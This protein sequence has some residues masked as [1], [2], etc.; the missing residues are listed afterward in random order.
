MASRAALDLIVELKGNADKEL[1]NLSKEATATGKS[2]DDIGKK[3]DGVFSKLGGSITSMIS[4]MALAGAGAA[5]L[6][7]FL[8]AATKAAIEEEVGVD[9]LNQ[10]LKNNGF[11]TAA[12]DVAKYITK[13]EKL[14]FADDE[15]RD[16]LGYLI[17]ATGDVT[18]AQDLQTI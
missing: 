11:E 17:T 6:G 7:G 18:K 15:L 13:T 2:F 9:R 8:V 12:N 1:K 16:S 4:P 3:G 10:T 5:A 14:A